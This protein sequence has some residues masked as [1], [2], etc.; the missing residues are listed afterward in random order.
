MSPTALWVLVGR[1][2]T[3]LTTFV[4]LYPGSTTMSSP[5]WT[6]LFGLAIAGLVPRCCLSPSQGQA[7]PAMPRGGPQKPLPAC[8][9]VSVPCLLS[10][11]WCFCF[12]LGLA[13]HARMDK[14]YLK[15]A[16]VE[17]TIGR[18][19]GRLKGLLS[20]R[21]RRDAGSLFWVP[22]LEASALCDS[23]RCI[24]CGGSGGGCGGCC[25]EGHGGGGL[26]SSALAGAGESGGRRGGV[27]ASE[28]L[29]ALSHSGSGSGG[30]P[31][32][33]SRVRFG[34]PPLPESERSR[35]KEFWK[36]LP[37]EDKHAHLALSCQQVPK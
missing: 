11:C 24:T 28:A 37:K 14:R 13:P 15:S 1:K 36:S 7:V 2:G 29:T 27:G 19:L 5:S 32:A 9:A 30:G 8:R 20:I 4:L 31:G 33:M 12:R 3:A 16:A 26:E 22:L 34:R 21:S 10:C 6:T 23:A 17:R 18:R 35:L 25:P